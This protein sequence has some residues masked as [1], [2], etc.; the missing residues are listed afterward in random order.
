MHTDQYGSEP[1]VAGRRV[2]ALRL[3]W[4]RWFHDDVT[5]PSH[6]T[7]VCRRCGINFTVPWRQRDSSGRAPDQPKAEPTCIDGGQARLEA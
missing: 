3:L 6:G 5:W 4:C 2:G 1:H 7:Y